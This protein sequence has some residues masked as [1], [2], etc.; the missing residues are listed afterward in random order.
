MCSTFIPVSLGFNV[1]VSKM[2]QPSI[3]GSGNTLYVGGYGPDN[4]TK[5]QDAIDDSVDGD[6]FFV[7]D[8]SSPYHE[9]IQIN[10]SINLIGEDRNTTIID[11]NG[12]SHNILIKSDVVSI[13]E[14]T[15]QNPNLYGIDDIGF[16][17]CT[18]SDNIIINTFG[19]IR[20]WSSN[21]RL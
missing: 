3:I 17:F 13:H 15:L 10:K 14:F 6:I 12:N 4:Y 5:I 19:G 8:D 20:M 21:T 16:G 7:Y 18:F 1:K 9:S 2:V 11:A